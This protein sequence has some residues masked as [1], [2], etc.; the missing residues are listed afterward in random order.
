M[1]IPLSRFEQCIDE[2]ILKR[3]LSYFVKDKVRECEEVAPGIY[4]AVVAG[5]EDYTVELRIEGEEV[6][7]HICN[8]P[9]DLGPICKHI[10]AVLFYLQKDVFESIKETK[11]RRRATVEGGVKKSRK[12]T[13]PKQ[14]NEILEKM[15]IDEL[16]QFIRENVKRNSVLK[17]TL[18]SSFAHQNANDSQELYS[19]QIRSILRTAAGR[20]GFIHWNQTSAVEKQVTDLLSTA[21]KQLAKNNAKSAIFICTAVLEEMTDALQYADD[22]NGE[23]GGSIHFAL[24]LLCDIAKGPMPE[25][26]RI[27]LLEYCLSAFARRVFSGWDWH[28]SVIQLAAD[29]FKSEQEAELVIKHLWESPLTEYESRVAQGIELNIIRTTKGEIVADEFIEQHRSNP[30]IRREAIQTSIRHK[31]Y[32]RATSIAKEGVNHDEKDKP[33]LVREW[34]EWLLRIAQIQNDEEKIIEY[35]RLLF[36]DNF[37]QQ[38]DY[39]QVMKSTVRQDAW[40]DFVEEIINDIRSKKS[41]YDI[42]LIANIF[43]REE[44]WSRLLELVAQNPSLPTIQKYEKHLSKHYAKEIVLLYRDEV[45][46]YMENNVG[47][48]HYQTVCKYLRRMIKLRGREVVEN[49]VSDFR[50][51]Y[52]QRTAMMEELARI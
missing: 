19:K 44:W 32:E 17:N 51:Q 9:Y 1:H 16:R 20:D 25:E 28:L 34:F 38:Q 10:V 33:G 47:R 3:G 36:I 35:A 26:I 21:Q 29:I 45:V 8:C 14:V 27:L 23:I 48:N 13:V 37:R 24:E 2:I 42:E 5:S 22:S 4:E 18:L 49:V 15:T 40:K 6:I 7:E 39:Y 11:P 46:K 41:W 31:D 52:A 50:R 12:Q 30:I 43:I